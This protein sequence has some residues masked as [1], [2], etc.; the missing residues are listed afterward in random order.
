ML[1]LFLRSSAIQVTELT[2]H[3]VN[4][5]APRPRIHMRRTRRLVSCARLRRSR[6]GSIVSGVPIRRMVSSLSSVS[7]LICVEAVADEINSLSNVWEESSWENCKGPAR[8]PGAEVQLKVMQS[9][10]V[11]VLQL[12]LLGFIGIDVRRGVWVDIITT[13]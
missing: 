9:V 2:E 7:R 12:G 6:G 11:S 5:S 13:P 10:L 8:G 3:R 4:C 1:Y